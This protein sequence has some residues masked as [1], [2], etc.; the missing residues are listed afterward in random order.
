M[1]SGSLRRLHPQVYWIDNVKRLALEKQAQQAR[2]QMQKDDAQ[3]QA[4]LRDA[5][6]ASKAQQRQA[7]SAQAAAQAKATAQAK[8][9]AK[10]EKAQAPAPISSS[11]RAELDETRRGAI[12]D[13][14][15]TV[16]QE[17]LVEALKALG[18]S[19]NADTWRSPIVTAYLA[20]RWLELAP[21]G[22][23]DATG[24]AAHLFV[25]AGTTSA[26]T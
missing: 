9:V 12:N 7:L 3:A 10:A 2:I 11:E 21:L 5:S 6:R 4:V 23:E 17:H 13:I 16:R 24:V 19:T 25:S 8:A 20:G 18:I 1:T 15:V 14:V 26:G 22:I